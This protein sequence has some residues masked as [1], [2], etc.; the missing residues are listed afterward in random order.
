MK[1]GSICGRVA[2]PAEWKPCSDPRESALARYT[3][4][5]GWHVNLNV[6]AAQAFP[7]H[8]LERAKSDVQETA[9][10]FSVVPYSGA[11][12]V[13]CIMLV[14]LRE[15]DGANHYAPSSL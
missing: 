2:L 3:L 6:V 9:S 11:E 13:M 15:G 10:R 4:C 12:G 14:V 7:R 8:C 1:Q 5:D